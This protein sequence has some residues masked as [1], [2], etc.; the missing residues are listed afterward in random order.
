MSAANAISYGI[1]D[2]FGRPVPAE[3]DRKTIGVRAIPDSVRDRQSLENVLADVTPARLVSIFSAADYG[4]IGRQVEL[5]Q[6]I[7]IDAHISD[8]LQ[9]RELAV[10]GL[11]W[12]IE[13]GDQTDQA[14]ECADAFKAAW[15]KLRPRGLNELLLAA[16]GQQWA[17][18]QIFWDLSGKQW[19]PVYYEEVDARRLVWP[20]ADG[21]TNPTVPSLMGTNWSPT[22]A[23]PLTPGS[24]AVHSYRTY[25]GRPGQGALVRSL[26]FWWMVKRWASID[27][28]SFVETFGKPWR[29]VKYDPNAAPAQITTILAN[30]KKTASDLCI[31]IPATAELQ[32]I[33]AMKS[34]GSGPHPTLIRL[35]DDQLSQAIVGSTT[36]TSAAENSESVSSPT[37]AAVRREIRDA[38][39]SRLAETL[40]R[41]ICVPFGLWN[42][43]PKVAAPFVTPTLAE[44][45]DPNK[46]API[47]ESAA[48]LRMKVHS[49]QLYADLGL[50]RPEDV[51]EVI[52]LQP[53][54]GGMDL[55]GGLMNQ[56]SQEAGDRNRE[57]GDKKTEPN[58]DGQDGQDD[59]EDES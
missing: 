40:Y 42:Y 9:I 2:R 55:L 27:Y 49:E 53:A 56:R 29:V 3:P 13:A 19:T 10:L 18:A 52:E 51:E 59:G 8:C 58:K 32:L 34:G 14:K 26:A 57:A 36:V 35:A 1:L 15:E 30:L 45:P 41:D 6:T 31:A 50:Q 39:A 47:Y 17:V 33:E 5:A 22:T 44:K 24:F 28:V 37:H 20:Q 12:T 11:D 21:E 38:D 48:R 16:I 25:R 43:G 23:V 4:Y 46:R 54:G 7:R